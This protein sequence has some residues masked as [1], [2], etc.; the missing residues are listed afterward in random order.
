LQSFPYFRLQIFH[1]LEHEGTG[2]GMNSI[3]DGFKV[4]KFLYLQISSKCLCVIEVKQSYLEY[5]DVGKYHFRMQ[6]QIFSGSRL[7]GKF[8]RIW[9]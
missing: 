7:S 2:G 1:R 6:T 8:E 5:K 4:A 3:V 9:L